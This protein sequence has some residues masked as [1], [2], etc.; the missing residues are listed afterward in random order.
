M[1]DSASQSTSAFWH[2]CSDVTIATVA[3]GLVLLVF[4][5]ITWCAEAVKRLPA[6]LG[7]HTGETRERA[8]RQFASCGVPTQDRQGDSRQSHHVAHS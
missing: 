4:Y 1:L 2:V 3:G 6:V 5:P 7:L 8:A